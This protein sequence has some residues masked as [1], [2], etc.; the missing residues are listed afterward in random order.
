MVETAEKLW[1]VD[2]FLAWDDGTDRRYELVH[3]AVVMMAP[4]AEAHGELVIRLGAQLRAGLQPPCRVI[5]EAGILVPHRD[6]S[7]YQAD[8]AVTCAPRRPDTRYLIDPVVV[9]E[10]M[11]PSTAGHDQSVKLPDYRLIPSVQEILMVSSTARR[12]E[13]W[14]RHEI[15][16]WVQDNIAAG[17]L[18]LESAGAEV[19]LAALYEDV[20]P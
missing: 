10:V 12:V 19:D 2:E 7:F 13:W 4:P 18:T 20:L 16:W 8:L 14:R 17:R 1:T 5:G 6:D 9:I 15:G 11:S 3:G